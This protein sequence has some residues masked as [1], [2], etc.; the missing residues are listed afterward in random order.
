MPRKNENEKFRTSR[1]AGRY[2]AVSHTELEVSA[3]SYVKSYFIMTHIVFREAGDSKLTLSFFFFFLLQGNC[4][5]F[6]KFISYPFY[7]FSL[8]PFTNGH[9]SRCLFLFID[10][11]NVSSIALHIWFFVAVS[12]SFFSK[13]CFTE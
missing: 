8:L 5:E 2:G 11:L 12:S 1:P 10:N 13:S 6:G 7:P 4:V 9:C 3:I